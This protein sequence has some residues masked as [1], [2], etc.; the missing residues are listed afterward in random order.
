MDV[1]TWDRA[2]GTE[3]SRGGRALQETL[4]SGVWLACSF[5]AKV[6]R[7]QEKRDRVKGNIS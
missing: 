5:L 1:L 4:E 2:G 7:D 3:G 6:R